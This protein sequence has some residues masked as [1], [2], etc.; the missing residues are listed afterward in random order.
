MN[1]RVLVG[2]LLAALL[3]GGPHV[4]NAQSGASYLSPVTFAPV[5]DSN[6]TLRLRAARFAAWQQTNADAEEQAQSFAA[7]SNARLETYR[8]DLDRQR[9]EIRANG[10]YGDL[11]ARHNA[12]DEAQ[13]A[14]ASSLSAA[15]VTSWQ[16]QQ[17]EAATTLFVQS[18]EIDPANPSAS[19]YLGEVFRRRGQLNEARDMMARAI[20]L[21]GPDT[22][23]VAL[24]R[25]ALQSLPAVPGEPEALRRLPTAVFD[26]PGRQPMIWDCEMCPEMVVIPAGNFNY[27][28]IRRVNIRAFAVS[29]FEVT[30]DEWRACARDGGCRSNRSP[31]HQDARGRSPVRNVSWTEAREY[32]AWLSRTTGKTYRLLTDPEWEY[33]ARA[34]TTTPFWW[35]WDASHEYAN[36]GQ[37]Y[38]RDIS[39]Q[40][41]QLLGLTAGRDRWGPTVAPVGQFPPNAFGLY[42]TAGN[43]YEWLASCE[44]YSVREDCQ[45]ATF[46]GGS[47]LSPSWALGNDQTFSNLTDRRFRDVGLRVARDVIAPGRQERPY[48]DEISDDLHQR[49]ISLVRGYIDGS[50]TRNGEGMSALSGP[51]EQI[52]PMQPN[53]DYRWQVNLEAGVAYRLIGA[54]DND[55][56]NLDMELI[57]THGSRVVASDAQPDDFPVVNFTPDR[58]GSF[59]IRLIMRA[60]S[61]APCYAG[62]RLL[63][64]RQ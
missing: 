35:G 9:Q 46:H 63:E 28:Y 27:S 55:C 44:D 25:A 59:E 60:C 62:G 64:R 37:E 4:A 18:L 5:P 38:P 3:C 42:D 21:G 11:I 24:A 41:S 10:P 57:D 56:S 49:L 1:G 33:V 17:Y 23:E 58:T 61:A 52:V 40:G 22:Q 47:F 31:E 48:Q 13:R 34:G 8:A 50:Q 32:V 2:L 20:A 45:R 30:Y 7:A 6:E 39:P 43:V 51:S 14:R 26:T 29:R 15:G 12:L 19:Y 16:A 54:C 53:G 36:Y